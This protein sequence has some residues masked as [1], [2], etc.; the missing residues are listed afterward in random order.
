MELFEALTRTEA[1]YHRRVAL[2]M[3]V[4]TVAFL[5]CWWPYAVIFMLGDRVPRIDTPNIS[6]CIHIICL[7]ALAPFAARFKHLGTTYYGYLLCIFPKYLKI[8][9]GRRKDWFYGMLSPWLI[10]TGRIY[11]ETKILFQHFIKCY[12]IINLLQPDK[13]HPVH[14]HQREGQGEREE[15]VH[16]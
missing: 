14:L 13:S 2:I 8:F 12:L 16:V 7:P 4:I 6:K 3:A 5:V 10:L 15:P 9:V 1:S 11:I